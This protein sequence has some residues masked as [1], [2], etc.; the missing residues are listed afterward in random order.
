M[1]SIRMGIPEM[2]EFRI[3]QLIMYKITDSRFKSRIDIRMIAMMLLL[4]CVG[5]LSYIFANGLPYSAAV[6]VW[7]ADEIR[8]IFIKCC[9]ICVLTV[10]TATDIKARKI[11]NACVLSLIGLW[12]IDLVFQ[13]GM[14]GRSST[15]YQVI[16][17]VITAATLAATFLFARWLTNRIIRKRSLGGG[18]I[19]LVFAAGLILGPSKSIYMVLIA[20]V[21]AL[22]TFIIC[23]SKNTDGYFPL[24]PALAIA[25]GVM[26]L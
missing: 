4:A 26:L 13:S 1:F 9:I 14:A 17:D 11:P 25:T 15:K 16:I 8:P 2:E 6:N 10:V 5:M 23:R 19:K 7:Q 12:F 24:G 22:V 3:G 20:C 18:D 21:M